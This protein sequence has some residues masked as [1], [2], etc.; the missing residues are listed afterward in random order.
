MQEISL[1]DARI[2]IVDDQEAD[3]RLLRSILK[4]AGANSNLRSTT[5]PRKTVPYLAEFQPDLIVL[6]LQMPHL[7]GFAVMEAL[8]P[9]IPAGTY[10]PILAITTET[11]PEVKQRA[12]ASGAKDFLTKPFDATEVVLRIQ[13]LLETR[14]LHRVLEDQNSLVEAKVRE[15]TRG[16]DE[17]QIEIL[18]RLA[19]V[20]EFRDDLTGKHT[21]RVGETAAL[22]AWALGLPE[23]EAEM[24]RRAA[25]LHDVGKIGIPD[26]ILLKPSGLT[27]EEFEE[28]KN[29]TVI[30]ARI[31]S[32]SRLPVLK[33]AEEIALTHHENWDGT[34]YP[35]K[36]KG[37]V[38]PL[39]GRIVAVADAYDAFTHDRPYRKALS[40][41][42][43]WEIMWDG[44]G[45]Q[46]DETVL[47][48]FA[49]TGIGRTGDRIDD[50]SVLRAL[51]RRHMASSSRR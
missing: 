1:K 18:Q 24:I 20:A 12:L 3:I 10:F 4:R 37:D 11:S 6:D 7:D 38:I 17:A 39:V 28:M 2:L 48:A 5:D 34:G 22:L 29:H 15:H 51:H 43:T 19:M 32:G 46:W 8:K 27:R 45:T 35:L 49:S 36:L 31:L 47:E 9:L 41:K 25:P 33:L 50:A 16:H 13:N 40:H 14:D 21:Q 44:A 30:G 42:E 23:A 26:R